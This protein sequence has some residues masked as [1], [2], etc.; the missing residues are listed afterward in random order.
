MTLP[1]YGDAPFPFCLA[2]AAQGGK[3]THVMV[4]LIIHCRCQDS[5]GAAVTCITLRESN[6]T[7]HS[8]EL[9]LRAMRVVEGPCN[10]T[11]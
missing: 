5:A 11:Q 9:A 2:S 6:V 3:D 4:G 8:P 10:D 7:T 1:V